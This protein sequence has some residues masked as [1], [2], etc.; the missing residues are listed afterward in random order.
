[1]AGMK[2]RPVVGSVQ[3]PDEIAVTGIDTPE[4]ARLQLSDFVFGNQSL[5]VVHLFIAPI[6]LNAI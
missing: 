1:M 3:Q 2:S 6:D 4:I 5:D